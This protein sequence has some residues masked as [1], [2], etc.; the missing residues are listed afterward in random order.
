LR[1]SEW[2]K[3]EG[4]GKTIHRNLHFISCSINAVAKQLFGSLPPASL[5]RVSILFPDPW[6][7]RNHQK[8]RII[9]AKLVEQLATGA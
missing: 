4:E 3:A 1:D 2:K 5:K 9:Q 7:R 6:A 8:R